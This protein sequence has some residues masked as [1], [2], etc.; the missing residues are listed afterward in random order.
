EEMRAL[1]ESLT[2]SVPA[3]E[4]NLSFVFADDGSTDPGL[5]AVWSLP[6]FARAD[7]MLFHSERN[8][9]FVDT[10]NRHIARAA[11]RSD[12]VLLNSDTMVFGNVFRTL[13]EEAYSAC[14]IA[15]V[16]PLT[17]NGT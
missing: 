10:V 13:Q 7:V 3:P 2:R 4:K 6:F 16:T 15:S 1:V 17:N 14:R 5:R 8:L 11:P 12:I 9:G